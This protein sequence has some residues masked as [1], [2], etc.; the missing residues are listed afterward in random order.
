M[1]GGFGRHSSDLRFSTLRWN[2]KVMFDSS[3]TLTV[4]TIIANNAEVG[5]LTNPIL[6]DKPGTS[7]ASIADIVEH[8]IGLVTEGNFSFSRD[9]WVQNYES[10]GPDMLLVPEHPS[11]L[12]MPSGS[13]FGSQC[14]PDNY[15][16]FMR[17][18]ISFLMSADMFFDASI[19]VKM[20]LLKNG[21][22]VSSSSI[23]LRNFNSEPSNYP[24]TLTLDDIIVVQPGDTLDINFDY[25]ASDIFKGIFILPGST[26]SYANFELLGFTTELN[27]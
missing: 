18:H 25:Q 20:N 9:V 1:L 8:Y 14:V 26:N 2:D 7:R 5:C 23:K 19:N 21:S 10:A 6:T 13:A 22:V 16:A 11:L 24:A 17:V 12:L 15:F 4:P 3:G 27:D